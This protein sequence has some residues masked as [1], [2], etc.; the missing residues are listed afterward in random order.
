MGLSILNICFIVGYV[1]FNFFFSL[2]VYNKSK[3]FYTLKLV[4]LNGEI[5]DIHQKYKDFSKKDKLSFIRIF[6]GINIF[7]WLKFT[8]VI[9]NCIFCIIFLK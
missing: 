4:E 6:I 7:F 3:P 2:W 1:L 9:L 8:L 5:V